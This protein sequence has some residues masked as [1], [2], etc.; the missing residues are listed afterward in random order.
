LWQSAGAPLLAT[1]PAKESPPAPD[2]P[3]PAPLEQRSGLGEPTVAAGVS[4]PIVNEW[5]WTHR[6]E[7]LVTL[8]PSQLE[9]AVER[10]GRLT[11]GQLSA[12]DRIIG[13]LVAQPSPELM[14]P[15]IARWQ[16]SWKIE[17]SGW[18]DLATMFVVT[19]SMAAQGRYYDVLRLLLNQYDTPFDEATDCLEL[20]ER[21]RSG[22][23][24]GRWRDGRAVLEIPLTLLVPWT[25]G[26]F[27]RLVDGLW[28]ATNRLPLLRQDNAGTELAVG[29]ADGSA[30]RAFQ[31]AYSSAFPRWLPR[32]PIFAPSEPER[33]R[34]ITDIVRAYDQLDLGERTSEVNSMLLGAVESALLDLESVLSIACPGDVV[35]N[36]LFSQP[37]LISRG[38]LK[39]GRD[40]FNRL[41]AGSRTQQMRDL[42]A[43]VT[44]L[45]YLDGCY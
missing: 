43:K 6:P 3:A 37:D 26:H 27:Q 18:L 11:P 9:I 31:A 25:A 19:D 29:G 2:R 10:L 45:D 1:R 13:Q 34:L 5:T 35:S 24:E 40:L 14:A 32:Q 7:S 28:Q 4:L 33:A 20:V 44:E 15:A 39:L 30:M 21:T 41:P 38:H 42:N 12:V 16:A 23:C 22:D 8:S 36:I 17:P